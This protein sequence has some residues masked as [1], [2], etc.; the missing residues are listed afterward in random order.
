MEQAMKDAP[1]NLP[2]LPEWMLHFNGQPTRQGF[3]A[4]DYARAAVL[5]DRAGRECPTCHNAYQGQPA[6]TFV[7]A[8][9]SPAE[10]DQPVAEVIIGGNGHIGILPLAELEHEQPLYARPRIKELMAQERQR[11]SAEPPI[12]AHR[13]KT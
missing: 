11:K 9:P 4:Q 10:P 6:P 3:E 5:A 8:A 2:L 13:S 12:P 7:S 1:I